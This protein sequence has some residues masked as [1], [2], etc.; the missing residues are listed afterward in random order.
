MPKMNGLEATQRIMQEAPTRIIV[1]SSSLDS[2]QL[3]LTFS[4]IQAGALGALDTPGGAEGDAADQRLINMVRAMAEVSVVRRWQ[5]AARPLPA[6]DGAPR[7]AAAPAP[8]RV[9]VRLIALATSTGGPGA[10]QTILQRLPA[11]FPIPIVVVQHIAAG[12]GA[13]LVNWLNGRT[14]LNVRLAASGDLPRAGEVLLAPEEHH[15]RL[16]PDGALEVVAG[17]PV[18]GVRPSADLLFG[19]LARVLGSAAAGIVLTGM[20]DDGAD[21]V[22]ALRAAGA[23]TFAQDEDSSVVF[24]MPKEAAATGCV[25]QIVPLDNVADVLLDLAREAARVE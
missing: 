7:P 23:R 13:G 25:D 11:T 16:R 20:G 15:L 6:L 14:P 21:G 24:G 1:V 4:A 10:L 8:S 17:D 3:D 18:K 22:R 19:S 5:R 12:F 2:A 9:P